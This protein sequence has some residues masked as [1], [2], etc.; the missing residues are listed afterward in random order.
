MRRNRYLSRRAWLAKRR[1]EG[2]DGLANF[3]NR[4][5]PVGDVQI[6]ARRAMDCAHRHQ[7]RWWHDPDYFAVERVKAARATKHNGNAT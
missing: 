4:L 3:R 2:D 1:A 7:P 5:F 6:Y